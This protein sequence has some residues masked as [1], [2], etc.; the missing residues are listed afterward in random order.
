ML[1][2]LQRKVA[3]FF[4]SNTTVLAQGGIEVKK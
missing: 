2:S 4:Y 1:E 3:G